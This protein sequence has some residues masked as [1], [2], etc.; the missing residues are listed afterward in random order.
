MNVIKGE[1]IILLHEWIGGKKIK[2]QKK[3]IR[4]FRDSGMK[5]LDVKVEPLLKYLGLITIQLA[6]N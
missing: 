4:L 2:V 6:K 1:R 5:Q 3:M